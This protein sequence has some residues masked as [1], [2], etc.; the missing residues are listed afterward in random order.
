MYNGRKIIWIGLLMAALLCVIA[1]C[2]GEKPVIITTTRTEPSQTQTQPQTQTTAPDTAQAA[3]V[4]AMMR[5]YAAIVGRLEQYT[6]GESTFHVSNGD[7]SESYS[8][9][10]AFRYCYERLL[11]LEELDSFLTPGGWLTYMKTSQHPNLDRQYYLDQFTILQD[12]CVRMDYVKHFAD[13]QKKPETEEAYV[14]WHYYPDGS[15]AYIENGVGRLF[16]LEHYA[17]FTSADLLWDYDDSGRIRY[18]YFGTITQ[19]RLTLIPTYDESGRLIREE[20]YRPKTDETERV[21]TY[22]YDENG[23]LIRLVMTEPNGLDYVMECIYDNR[24]RLVRQVVV[25][26]YDRPLRSQ[27]DCY[28]DENGNLFAVLG[29]GGGW[30]YYFTYDEQGRLLSRKRYEQMIFQ[31]D[32]S[33]QPLPGSGYYEEVFVYGDKYIYGEC[34]ILPMPDRSGQKG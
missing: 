16:W 19:Q 10:E 13:P 32:G 29:G 27:Y 18:G 28:Y 26:N 2:A 14:Y 30:A 6:P 12:V 31:E 1:G 25:Q 22:E 20:Q 21:Y 15:V 17:W 24:G 9:D 5:D 34:T 23:N 7:R 8:G 33:F 3:R 4:T 11:E